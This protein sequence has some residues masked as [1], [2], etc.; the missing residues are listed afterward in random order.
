MAFRIVERIGTNGPM[1]QMLSNAQ[2]LRP[3]GHGAQVVGL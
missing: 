2:V 1:G 3:V